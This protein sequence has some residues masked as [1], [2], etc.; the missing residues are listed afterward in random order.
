MTSGPLTGVRVLEF[1]AIGPTPFAGMQ[2]ADMGA[3][4]V[5]IVR[6]GT[7]PLRGDKVVGRGRRVLHFDLKD[8]AQIESALALTARADILLEGFRPGVMEKM[9]LGPEVA[10]QRNNRLVYGRMTGWGQTGPLAKTAG[11][12]INFIAL[13][14]ALG[15]IGPAERPAVPLNL[16]GDYGG[17]AMFLLTGVLAALLHARSTGHGQVVDCAMCDGSASLM[18]A[19]Y[20][21]M[22]EG[23]FVDRRGSNFIDG[24]AH[25]YATFECADGG[26]VSVGALE[27]QFRNALMDA[28]DVPAEDPLRGF[29]TREEWPALRDRMAAIFRRRTRDE[30]CA[31]LEG[32]DVCFAP[33]L[34]LS[35]SPRHPHLVARGTFVAR[36][37]VT[38]PAPAPRFSATPGALRDSAPTSMEALD[39]DWGLVGI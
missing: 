37:G 17:G 29:A 2:L 7:A 28:L 9:G 3:D 39:A 34:S 19:F 5:R 21:L 10:F 31:I 4:V 23:E 32:T 16:V 11:H 6:P 27:P 13:T 33:V 20:G 26:F 38:H 12:D 15:A 36:G 30:W 1:G 14:G 8:P 35:E 24:S 22:A 18:S 25:F